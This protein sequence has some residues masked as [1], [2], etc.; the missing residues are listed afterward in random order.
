MEN[1][2]VPFKS[3][4]GIV[5]NTGSDCSDGDGGAEAC[6]SKDIQDDNVSCDKT[7]EGPCMLSELSGKLVRIVGS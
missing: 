5:T 4:D 7:G 6:C 3:V 1:A 2:V